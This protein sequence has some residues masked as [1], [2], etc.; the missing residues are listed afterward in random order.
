[1]HRWRIAAL[2]SVSL[3]GCGT[4]NNLGEG[5]HVYGGVRSLGLYGEPMG[6]MASYC[7][8]PFSFA[9]D[10]GILPITSL[11]ELA[12]WITG[13]P[14]RSHRI[15]SVT[16]L[17]HRTAV[18][19]RD[20]SGLDTALELYRAWTGSYPRSDA[21][22]EA[23]YRKSGDAEP[24]KWDGVYLSGDGPL[25]DPWGQPYAYRF[26]GMRNPKGYELFSSGPDRTPDTWDD[27]G[28][29]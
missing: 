15:Y 16:E 17:G 10:T 28:P 3:V 4:I 22:L 8:L 14:A 19:K 11:A 23:I 24:G 18:A 25:L 12:R 29:E 5:P 21:G 7:D 27:I 6:N 20:L 13:W 2:L 26:P 1:M 9:L